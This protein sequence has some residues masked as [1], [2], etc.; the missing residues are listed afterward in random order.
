MPD[1]TTC[2][3]GVKFQTYFFSFTLPAQ[4]KLQLSLSS[5]IIPQWGIRDFKIELSACEINCKSCALSADGSSVICSLCYPNMVMI[6]DKCS[7]PDGY[8]IQIQQKYPAVI[9]RLCQSR[10]KK[11]FSDDGEKCL[12]CYQG[13]RMNGN[14]C[15]SE[16]SKIFLDIYIFL[17]IL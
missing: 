17:F 5:P 4:P 6:D 9:C 2:N 15:E 11:C 10:C 8:Y 7:C 13:F 14:S 16:N 3:S 12:E 1:S